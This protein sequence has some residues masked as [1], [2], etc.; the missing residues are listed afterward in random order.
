MAALPG[1]CSNVHFLL[2]SC[3]WRGASIQDGSR[4]G[5]GFH[6]GCVRRFDQLQ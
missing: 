1:L 5:M 4:D 3:Y 6:H 2:K